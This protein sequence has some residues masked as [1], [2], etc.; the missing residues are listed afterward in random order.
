MNLTYISTSSDLHIT[1]IPSVIVLQVN[2]INTCNPNELDQFVSVEVLWPS[3][4]N[5]AMSSAISL[6]NH[7]FTEVGV[8]FSSLSG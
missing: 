2:S 7:T 5:E 8:G 1:W 6:L 3:Q 4:P